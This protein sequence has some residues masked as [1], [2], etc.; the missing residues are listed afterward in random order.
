VVVSPFSA[1]V[2]IQGPHD[3]NPVKH[4]WPVVLGT[5]SSASIA[6]CHSSASCSALGN[7]VMQGGVAERDQ[8]FPA[9]HHDRTENTVDPKT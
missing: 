4:R 9:L 6:A 1:D 8:R 2:T 5:S 3:A 7:L